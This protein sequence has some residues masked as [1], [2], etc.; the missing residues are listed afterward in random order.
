MILPILSC[1]EKKFKSVDGFS[2]ILEGK[3]EISMKI[4]DKF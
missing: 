2:M 3:D 4:R 1:S